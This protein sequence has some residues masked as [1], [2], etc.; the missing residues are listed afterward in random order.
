MNP[1]FVRN[2]W[3]EA[4]P[5]R[6]AL[7]AGLLLLVFAVTTVVVNLLADLVAFRLAPRAEVVA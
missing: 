6:L 7:I 2:L 5:F 4:G 3:L 1:E